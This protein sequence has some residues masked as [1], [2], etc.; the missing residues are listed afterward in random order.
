MNQQFQSESPEETF[1]FAEKLAVRLAGGEIILFKGPLG[2]GKTLFTKGLL[3]G[4]GFD[5]DEV[6]SPSFALVN[7]YKADLDVFHIDLWRLDGS[8]DP[9]FAVGLEEILENEKAV[10]VIEW[11]ERLLELDFGRPLIIVEIEGASEFERNITVTRKKTGRAVET[12]NK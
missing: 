6:T 8:S 1:A 5:S 12:L 4:L 11:S 7:H 9:A 2:A 10:V 3:S